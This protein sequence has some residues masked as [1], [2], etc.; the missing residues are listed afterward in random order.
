MGISDNNIQ[1]AI[2]IVI[3]ISALIALKQLRDQHE[4]YRREKALSYSNLYHSELRK[5]KDILEETFDI[6]SSNEPIPIEK[7][8]EKIR[9]NKTLRL[10]LNYL[11][12]YYENVGLAC[13]NEIA[14][15]DILF[16]LMAS[17]LVSFR[18][19]L[20]PYIVDRRKEADNQRLWINFERLAIEW[21]NK[22][23]KS[24]IHKRSKLGIWTR[25]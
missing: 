11:L 18:N 21:E 9:T 5:T 14:D 4:W 7:I 24:K 3:G 2:L 23:T 20:R 25:K 19:K 13:F 15:E 12:T 6:V 10:E 17:T 22:L 1:L 16:D 8:K